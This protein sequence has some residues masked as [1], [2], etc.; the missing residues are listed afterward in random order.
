[1]GLCAA[2]AGELSGEIDA[3]VEAKATILIKV[4]VQSLEISRGVDDTDISGLDEVVC[5]NQVLLVRSNL[6]VVGTNSG[7]VLIGVIE[8]LD[9]VEVANVQS[10]DVVGSCQSEVDKLSILG[11][12]GAVEGLIYVT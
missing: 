4:D 8:T 7:L 5:D 1:M 2:T 3:T 11:D 9:V 12:V 6:D 10:G